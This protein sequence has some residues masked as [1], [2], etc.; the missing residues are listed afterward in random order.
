MCQVKTY[1]FELL[2]LLASLQAG[3]YD[4]KKPVVEDDFAQCR[5]YQSVM[6]RPLE[7]DFA[8][9]NHPFRIYLAYGTAYGHI[10][11]TDSTITYNPFRYVS[12][13]IINDSIRYNI[14][15]LENNLTSDFGMIRIQIINDGFDR[16]NINQVSC[17]IYAYGM[18]FWGQDPD[19]MVNYAVPAG[20]GAGTIFN[21]TLWIGGI[22][23]SG[24]LCLAAERYRQVGSDFFGGPVMDSLAYGN[25]QD[26]I[27]HKVWKLSAGEIAFHE[28]HWQD[29]GYE[30]VENII[31]WPGNGDTNL[32]QAWKLA[33]F[34]D[35][36]ADGRYDPMDGDSPSIKGDQAIFVLNNDDRDL[37]SESNG[38]KIGAEIH[39]LYYAYRAEDDSALKYTVFAD[40]DMINRSQESY[41]DVYIGHFLD[42]D[43]GYF[44]DDFLH[45]DTLLESAICYNGV[46]TDGQGLPGQY[47]AHPPAQS[48]TCLNYEMDGFAYFMNW[49]VPQ[50]MQDPSNAAE[51]YNYLRGRWRDSTSFT[52]GGS[53]YGGE[54][55]VKYVFTGDPVSNSG[56]T[57]LDSPYGPGDRKGLISTGPYEFNQGDTLHFVFALVFARDYS[58]DNLTSL[59]L[60]KEN[61]LQVRDFYANSLGIEENRGMVTSTYIFPNPCSSTLCVDLGQPGT[62]HSVNFEVTD[63]SGKKVKEGAGKTN[64]FSINVRDL[65]PGFYCIKLQT[66]RNS[67]TQKFVKY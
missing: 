13:H 50:V 63:I 65:V 35:L 61:I 11:V 28:Q 14:I 21:Q 36:N 34:I 1:L 37:H 43:I 22:N 49:N 19:S 5:V 60:L 47:G 26:M 40:Q 25:E 27:W 33:P 4:D 51:Y 45:C 32:G 42:Y 52:Y 31:K 64:Q 2:A 12:S 56:W 66:G 55:P 24:E 39:T 7:N 8:Y 44:M 30:P 48:F 54:V 10:E 20:S 9:D 23:S 41:H 18:Q 3:A 15:D 6:I 59:A 57:E 17:K 46:A 53:G 29:S 38:R 58:G 16:L 67:I 62:T